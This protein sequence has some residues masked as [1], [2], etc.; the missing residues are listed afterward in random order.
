MEW[1]CPGRQPQRQ[2]DADFLKKIEVHIFIS[3]LAFC[4]HVTLRRRLRDLAPGLTPRAALEKFATPQM[5]DVHLPTADERTVIPSRYTHPEA[6]VQI[7]LQQLKLELPAQTPPKIVR[8]TPTGDTGS[9]VKT[10]KIPPLIGKH[11]HLLTT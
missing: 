1:G 4:L 9:V 8:P 11:L 5:L 6:D 2:D 3:F 10:W 7:L